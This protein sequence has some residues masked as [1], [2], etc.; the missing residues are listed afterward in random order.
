MRMVISLLRIDSSQRHFSHVLMFLYVYLGR[1]H[2]FIWEFRRGWV[3]RGRDRV[4]RGRF[5]LPLVS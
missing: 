3:L 1:Q 2:A 5:L 4:A